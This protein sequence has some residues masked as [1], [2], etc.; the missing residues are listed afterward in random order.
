MT[1][2]LHWRIYNTQI[3][4]ARQ[5]LAIIKSGWWGDWVHHS[6]LLFVFQNFH[7]EKKLN[8]FSKWR[9]VLWSCRA[10]SMFSWVTQGHTYPLHFAQTLEGEDPLCE[11]SSG[12]IW[13]FCQTRVAPSWVSTKGPRTSLGF[14]V[15]FQLPNF[16]QLFFM[17][18]SGPGGCHATECP[19]CFSPQANACTHKRDRVFL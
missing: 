16:Q 13:E 15:H 8:S 6:F 10:A 17:E 4:Q 7:N 12:K 18:T 3:K 9:L 14:R 19:P 1:Y 5:I 2:R 11:R